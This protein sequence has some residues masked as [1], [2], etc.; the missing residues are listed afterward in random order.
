MVAQPN[1]FLGHAGQQQQYAEHHFYAGGQGMGGQTYYTDV[2]HPSFQQG[3][4]GTS[5]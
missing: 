3:Y 4:G 5:Y 1:L 2:Q